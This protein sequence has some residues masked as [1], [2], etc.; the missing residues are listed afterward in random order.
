MLQN[1][2]EKKWIAFVILV[3]VIIAMAFFG[4]DSY[5]STNIETYAAKIEG[6]DKF[7][8]YGGQERE[9]SQDQFRQRFDQ[10]REQ[11]RQRQGDAFNSLA[12]ESI[13]NKRLVLDAMVDEALLG[14]VAER[15]GITVS[16]KAV[17]DELKAM[18]QFQVEGKYSPESYRMTLTAQG[19][20]HAQFMASMRADM[21]RSTLPGQIINTALTSDAELEAFL[22]LSRQTRDLVLID[23]PTPA[24]P[25]EAPTDA[26]LKAWYDSNASRYRSEE[27]V[28][29]EYVEIDGSKLEVP[30]A[31]DEATLLQRYEDQ[32]SR[33]T[34]AAKR[35]VS[36]LLVSVAA[37]ADAATQAAAR[38]RIDR[39]AALAKAPGADFAAIVRENSDDAGSKAE[40]GD[41]G[42]IDD[43]TFPAEFEAGLKKLDQVGQISEPLR[44][45]DGWHLVQ[46]REF[47]PGSGRSFEEVR[48]EL[49]ADYLANERDRVFSDLS[50]RLI[51]L[52]YQDPTALAP[53]AEKMGLPLQRTGLFGRRD[54]AGIAAIPAVREAAF[55]D[56]QKVERQVS[57]TIEIAP[58]QVVVIHVVDVKPEAALPLDQVRDRVLADYNSD[59]LAKGSKAQAEALLERARKGES[60]EALATEVGRVVSTL[61]GV[62]REAQ[63]PPS[64]I[65][66]AF[67]LTAPADGKPS[68]AMFELAPDRH[69]LVSVTSITPGDLA[70]LDDQTRV[71]LRAQFAQARGRVEY[72]DFIKSL[73]KAYTI[74]VAEDRL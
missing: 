43:G 6:P 8:G 46:L 16:E 20:T 28:A 10:V 21:A 19:T 70:Q 5:F 52:I 72:Q 56:P 17:A 49:E 69:A 1:I 22:K 18:P 37:D 68:V 24:L 27:Q 23:L 53:A 3:P 74:S 31:A 26:E 14:L 35:V 11:E 7:M 63:L 47:T 44:T 34:T 42:Q 51:D 39:L 38:E 55:S 61:P 45:P 66:A 54:A 62:N 13:D 25:A 65:D 73:R 36:H 2:R 30:T 59:R 12:F 64:L 4:I 60:L 33:Y 29:L 50:G 41:L 48:A 67:Q 71:L 57:D 15:D 40:G 58:N 9:I 32:K